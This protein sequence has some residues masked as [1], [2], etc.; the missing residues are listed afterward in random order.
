M[1]NNPFFRIF[2]KSLVDSQKL[3]SDYSSHPGFAF[4]IVP[5]ISSLETDEQL[6]AQITQVIT[7]GYRVTIA[8]EQEKMKC[9]CCC[10]LNLSYAVRLRYQEVQKPFKES[11]L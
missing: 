4:V 5:S 3:L 1:K 6:R 7:E 11:V 8:Q 10:P 2:R 9:G